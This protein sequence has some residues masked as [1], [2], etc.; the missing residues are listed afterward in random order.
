MLGYDRLAS[1]RVKRDA[2]NI[3]VVVVTGGY[4]QVAFE[5]ESDTTAV[6]CASV[7]ERMVGSRFL[8][9]NV[10]HNIGP[11]VFGSSRCSFQI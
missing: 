11:V 6:V 9:G 3:T 10:F 4:K 8:E 7:T 5:A 2:L 1:L